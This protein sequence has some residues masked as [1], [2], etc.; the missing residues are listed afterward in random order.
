MNIIE[1]NK[2]FRLD[3]LRLEVHTP[4]HKAELIGK[5]GGP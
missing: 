2:R 5:V 4:P 1:V 3:S